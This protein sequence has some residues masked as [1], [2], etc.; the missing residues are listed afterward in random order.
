MILTGSPGTRWRWWVLA[1]ALVLVGLCSLWVGLRGHRVS[2]T[3]PTRSQHPASNAT[4]NPKLPPTTPV[5]LARSAPVAL[6]IPAIGVSVFVS[7]L[8]LNP[9]QSVQVPTDFQVPGWYRLGP[10]PGQVG[11]AV[12][13]GHVDS[14]QGPGV[15]YKLRLLVA[16]NNVEVTLA[17]GVVADF[18][19]TSVAIYPK[20]QF[21]AQQVYGS[22]GYSG[23]Q[24]VTCGGTFDSRSGHYLSNIVVYTSLVRTTPAI[25][26][27]AAR[28]RAGT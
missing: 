9:D 14:H 17:D 18:M 3:L 25:P 28:T 19:V 26:A 2:L 20:D 27:D 15:F 7:Q 4:G 6:S 10:S 8:G 23:L 24:L 11:S 5:G 22:H 12:I 1:G 16:G 21:P 13:L